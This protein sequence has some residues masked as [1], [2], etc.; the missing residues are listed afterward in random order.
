MPLSVKSTPCRALCLAESTP[1]KP[2]TCL[3]AMAVCI[4]PHLNP[5]S[6]IHVRI[7]LSS[8]SETLRLP[9]PSISRALGYDLSQRRVSYRYQPSQRQP[10]TMPPPI[11]LSLSNLPLPADDCIPQARLPSRHLL[12]ILP[13]ELTLLGRQRPLANRC[14]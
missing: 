11:P 13:P 3:R 7:G 12:H 10:L 5:P 8:A 2:I 14:L 1:G 9:F 6:T 4:C